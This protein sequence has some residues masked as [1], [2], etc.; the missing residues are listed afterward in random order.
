MSRSYREP[1]IT[2]GY[3]SK[4]KRFKK[5]QANRA[6][7]HAK[8][9]PDGKA[10]RKFSDSWDICDYKWC[11]DPKPHYYWSRGEMKVIE[12]IPGYKVWGK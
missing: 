2:D 7:R 9:V 6:I 8:E 11:W 4:S 10:Y 5:R 1:W 3:G 12:P